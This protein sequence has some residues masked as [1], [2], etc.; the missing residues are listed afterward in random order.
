MASRETD[1]QT[2]RI[3]PYLPIILFLTVFQLISLNPAACHHRWPLRLT[4][5]TIGIF[6]FFAAG[7]LHIANDIPI[8]SPAALT[9]G[10]F[11]LGRLPSIMGGNGHKG[12]TPLL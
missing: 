7:S 5:W 2:D 6:S 11:Q 3:F 12:R 9:G 8:L 4:I 10:Y 1:G